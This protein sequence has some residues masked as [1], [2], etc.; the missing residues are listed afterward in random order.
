MT[1]V[2]VTAEDDEDDGG[3]AHDVSAVAADAVGFHA[4][5]DIAFEDVGK[6]FA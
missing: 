1:N 3:D 5:A 6:A 2:E 4:L